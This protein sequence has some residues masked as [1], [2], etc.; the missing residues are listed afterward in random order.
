MIKIAELSKI[1][2]ARYSIQ[3]PMFHEPI[4]IKPFYS[5][6]QDNRP[7]QNT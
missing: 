3:E 2:E 5:L 7:N 4:S 6:Q 1:R